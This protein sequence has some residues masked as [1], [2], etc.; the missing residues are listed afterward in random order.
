MLGSKAGIDG[1]VGGQVVDVE[2]NGRFVDEDTL[3]Y[4]YK[5]KTA[6]LI[7]GSLMIGAILA[8]ADDEQVHTMEQVGTDIGIA[9]Q[10]QDDILDMAGDEKLIGKP[11]YSDE[12]N[13]KSTYAAIHGLEKSGEKVREYTERGLKRLMALTVEREEDRQFLSELL[14]SL[15]DRKS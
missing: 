6:A 9:F 3:M 13:E 8:G 11:L 1:M 12:K 10:I 2:N 7:E 4:V 15:V 14:A 5:N